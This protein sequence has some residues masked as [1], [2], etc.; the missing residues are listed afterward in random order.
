MMKKLTA[1]VLA[2]VM[3]LSL[4]VGCKKAEPAVIDP[5]AAYAKYAPDTVVMTINGSEV[6]WSEFFYMLYSGVAGLQQYVPEIVWSDEC[7]TGG[8]TNEEYV[9]KFAMESIK[10]FHIVDE[11]ATKMDVKLTAEDEKIIAEVLKSDIT[12]FCGEDGTEEDF[13]KVLASMYMTREVYDYVNRVSC[14]YTTVFKNMVGENGEKLTDEEIAKYIEAV[15]YITVKHILFKT[16]DDAR[17]PLSEEEQ[18]AASEQA[19]EVYAKLAEITEPEELLKQF[20]K[21]MKKHSQDPGLKFFP[22][23]YTFTKGKMVKEFE[24]AAFALAENQMSEIVKSDMG[25]HIILRLPTTRDSVVDVID[26]KTSNTV[27]LYAAM[28]VFD[29]AVIEKM[30]SADIQWMDGFEK[31]TAEKVFAQ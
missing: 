13:E 12:N 7:I 18:A 26:E 30:D 11:L 25:Y 15:P 31:L 9:W 3:C 22:D 21:Q 19:Q 14:I 20:D 1:V 24:D 23:G 4:L 17:Q 8:Q 28:D 29:A 5:D 27:G 10:Q 6:T 2:L 16:V